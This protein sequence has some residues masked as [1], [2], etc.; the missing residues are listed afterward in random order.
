MR[1]PTVYRIGGTFGRFVR[2]FGRGFGFG[3]PSRWF[4]RSATS[5]RGGRLNCPQGALLPIVRFY[6]KDGWEL[7]TIT[8]NNIAYLKRQI[9]KPTPKSAQSV[10]SAA[11]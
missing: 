5:P 8:A 7:V 11:A 6:G 4:R 3:F 9:R 1:S 10:K 2:Y